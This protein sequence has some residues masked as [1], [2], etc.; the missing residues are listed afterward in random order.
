[1]LFNQWAASP[2]IRNA[3]WVSCPLCIAG[4]HTVL[5]LLEHGYTVTIVDN[6]CNSYPRVLEHLQKLAGTMMGRCKFEEVRTVQAGGCSAAHC[7]IHHCGAC[8]ATP[9]AP[10]VSHTACTPLPRLPGGHA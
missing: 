4:S 3:L 1:M 9:L 10:Q 7:A 5:A 6:L 8:N 2:Y